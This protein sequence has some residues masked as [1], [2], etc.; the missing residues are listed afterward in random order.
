M[1]RLATQPTPAIRSQA[2][3]WDL[4]DWFLF[5]LTQSQ[6]SV[7]DLAARVRAL[8]CAPAAGA[9]HSA[10]PQVADAPWPAYQRSP[11]ICALARAR[12]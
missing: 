8:G 11:R 10:L 3:I 6:P 12:I 2:F 5:N 7:S 9:D 4:T 1:S